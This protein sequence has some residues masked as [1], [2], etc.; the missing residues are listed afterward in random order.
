M[1]RFLLSCVFVVVLIQPAR[2]AVAGEPGSFQLAAEAKVDGAGIFLNQV[3]SL[4]PNAT[5][6]KIRLAQAPLL[7]Q[8]ISLSRGQII[9]MAKDAFP[10]L[11]TTNWSGPEVVRIG[12]R[13]RNLC[14]AE[15]IDL[16]RTALQRDYV[17]GRG[18]LEIH[19]TRPWETTT[20]PDEPLTLELTQV[21]AAGVMANLVAGFELWCGKERMGSWQV[22]LQAH[23]WK[24]IPVAHAPVLRGDLLQE[25]DI[26][27]ER[28]D[29]LSQHEACIQFPV[30]DSFLEASCNIQA[31]MPVCSRMTRPRALVKR[32]QMVEAVFQ[33]GPMTISLKVETLEEGALGQT[34]R[35]RNPKTRREL[36]G[37]I[38]TEDLVLITL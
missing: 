31:G 20:A 6:P 13:V 32:G 29:M 23:V 19:L 1:N 27:L 12:R 10:A 11:D 37:K 33:D 5:L 9:S 36:Y 14:E 25:A 15:V 16:L 24:D 28:R 38:Q 35:V 21:P 17:G 4:S 2:R 8:T 3:L 22:P 7:G 18:T 26:I 34:V 30:T